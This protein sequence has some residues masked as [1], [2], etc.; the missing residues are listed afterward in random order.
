MSSYRVEI[1]GGGIN[2]HGEV[3]REVA[4]ELINLAEEAQVD[5]V[6]ERAPQMES[7]V[8]EWFDEARPKNHPERFAVLACYVEEKEGRPLRWD[9]VRDL[10]EKAGEDPPVNLGRDLRMAIDRGLLEPVGRHPDDLEDVRD[11]KFKATEE[12]KEVAGAT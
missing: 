10:F 5:P 4:L 3:P 8:R 7:E 12:G 11:A 9:E 2:Y 1:E 6:G